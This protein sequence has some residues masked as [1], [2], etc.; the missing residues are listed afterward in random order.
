MNKDQIVK[1]LFNPR[2]IFVNTQFDL[3]VADCGN[4]RIQ[5]FHLGD[6]NGITIAGNGVSNTIT[7]KCSIAIIVDT[8]QY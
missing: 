1:M 6:I 2:G 4:K 7:F 8:S 3:Y 5:Q